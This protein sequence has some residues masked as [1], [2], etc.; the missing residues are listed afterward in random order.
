M[1]WAWAVHSVW[2][3][4]SLSASLAGTSLRVG[5]N[6]C[7]LACSYESFCDH[8][9]EQYSKAAS[10]REDERTADEPHFN[11]IWGGIKH[12]HLVGDE[13]GSSVPLLRASVSHRAFS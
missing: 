5:S 12:D 11:N 9:S 2:S 6:H 3:N 10:C 7:G 8:L 4:G 13:R 1:G